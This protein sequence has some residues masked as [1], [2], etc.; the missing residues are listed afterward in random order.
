[1]HRLHAGQTYPAG[2]ASCFAGSPVELHILPEKLDASESE[3][4]PDDTAQELNRTEREAELVARMVLDL[5]GLGESATRRHVARTS[6]SGAIEYRE[7]EYRDIAILLR[8]TKFKSDEFA[9][10]L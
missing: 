7:I 1:S 3:S 5:V 9:S 8:A 6:A 10:A 4:K 2:S